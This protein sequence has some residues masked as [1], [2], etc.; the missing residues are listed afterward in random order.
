M[1]HTRAGGNAKAKFQTIMVLGPVSILYSVRP[2]LVA[3][4]GNRKHWGE[5][6]SSR[7]LA[8]RQ[9]AERLF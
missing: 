9:V 3:L 4:L 5:G 8:E 1:K 7:D 6:S 2:H